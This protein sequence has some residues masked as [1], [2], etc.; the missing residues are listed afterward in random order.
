MLSEAFRLAAERDVT[1]I[2][3]L[4]ASEDDDEP[5]FSLF[6]PKEEEPSSTLAATF[7]MWIEG[8]RQPAVQEIAAAWTTAYYESIG[9]ML[10][11][12]GSDDPLAD[13]RILTATIE[14]FVMDHI[15]RDA[16]DELR[17]SAGPLMRRL[18]TRLIGAGR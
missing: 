18:V 14:G 12:A 2:R 3:E 4:A 1:R 13:A 17:D 7:S 10:E 9:L 16:T 15:A 8:K 11:R 5:L 6:S